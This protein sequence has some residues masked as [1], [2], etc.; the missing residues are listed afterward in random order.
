VAAA[1]DARIPPIPS[2]PQPV[3]PTPVPAS[4]PPLRRRSHGFS[5][6]RRSR[7]NFDR[8]GLDAADPLWLDPSMKQPP[9]KPRLSDRAMAAKQ[10][11]E[12][13]AAEELRKNLRKRKEQ[14]R[15]R[16][17]EVK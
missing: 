10:E 4:S 14:A 17:E 2:R 12:A 11:R 16:D 5:P 15:A 8:T 1:A 6:R 13:R 9:Q 3:L 7:S